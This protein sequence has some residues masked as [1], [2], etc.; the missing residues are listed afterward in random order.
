MYTSNMSVDFAADA[1][2]GDFIGDADQATA[3]I[4][5]AIAPC[6]V[7]FVIIATSEQLIRSIIVGDDPEMLMSDL[8]NQFPDDTF[9]ILEN[10]TAG[11]VAGIVESIERADP[12]CIAFPV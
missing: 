5:F 7:G 6:S 3:A 9:E 11:L 4:R 12:T 8:Q 10:D 2:A 1:E